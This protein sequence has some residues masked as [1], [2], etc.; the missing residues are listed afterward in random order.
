MHILKRK[1]LNPPNLPDTLI[2][3]HSQAVLVEGG[4]RVLMSSQVGMDSAGELA[5][6]ELAEQT[7]AALDNVERL[8]TGLGGD[9]SRVVMLRIYLAES[10]R[11]D[12]QVVME[13][14]KHRFPVAPPAATWLIVYGLAEPE[15]LIAIEAEAVLPGFVL[16]S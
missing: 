2:E 4:T 1:L 8:L 6:P 9:L 14:L 13:A 15:W 3:G 12:Q 7:E 10:A 5:G 16:N 11:Y